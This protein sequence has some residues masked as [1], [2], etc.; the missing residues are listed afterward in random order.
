LSGWKDHVDFL[1]LLARKSGRLL[2]GGEPD[3][4]SVAKMVLVSVHEIRKYGHVLTGQND[5]IRGKLPWF[6]PPP[7]NE[8]GDEVDDGR[9]G[10]FGE[11]RKRK[12]DE[13]ESVPG[14]SMGAPTPPREEDAPESEEEDGF[15][16]FSSETEAQ[17]PVAAAEETGEPN[18]SFGEDMIPLGD[19]SDDEA[20]GENDEEDE[21]DED[22]GA[23]DEPG[24]AELDKD[25]PEDAGDAP[26]PKRRK[27]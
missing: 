23:S 26:K 10:R 24:G 7:I 8:G 6:T 22:D 9:E 21:D 2:K 27:R 12:R 18:G 15:D 25:E 11:M 16:G 14:T 5:F 4:D 3:I 1:E 20:E 19:S 17:P 13:V